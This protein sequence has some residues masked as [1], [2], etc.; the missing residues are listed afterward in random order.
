VITVPD[1]APTDRFL[2]EAL[3]LRADH[4]YPLADD[5][6]YTVHVYAIGDGGPNAQV[7]VIVNPDLPRAKYGS[8]G[9]HHIALRVPDGQPME[10]W[11][12]RI[13]GLGYRNSGIVDRHYF[14]SLYVR[15]PN[16]ILFELATEGPGFDVDGVTDGDRLTLPPFLEPRRAEIEKALRPI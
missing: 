11:E 4:T 14:T 12:R 2:R 16:H 10:E 15:E 9:V 1:L 7:H 8:G 13:S 6:R 3:G 5:A